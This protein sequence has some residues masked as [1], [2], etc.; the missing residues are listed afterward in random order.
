[1]IDKRDA[2]RK[3]E[4]STMRGIERQTRDLRMLSQEGLAQKD[5]NIKCLN[6][7]AACF[8]RPF[9]ALETV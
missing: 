8:R 7:A 5:A 6:R 9:Y 3:E 1:M 4:T 2:H